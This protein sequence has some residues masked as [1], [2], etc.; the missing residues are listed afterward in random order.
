MRLEFPF[1]KCDGKTIEAVVYG[2]RYDQAV[3]T[4]TD[5][6]FATI[7]AGFREYSEG[8]LEVC[9]GD[10]SFECFRDDQLIACGIVSREEVAKRHADEAAE[11]I[12]ATEEHDRRHYEQLKRKFG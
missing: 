11:R 3:V 5:G 9:D 10:F 1:S 6:T 2:E 8:D 12:R 4:F 7:K